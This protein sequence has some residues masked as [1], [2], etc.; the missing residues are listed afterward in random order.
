ML[1]RVCYALSGTETAYGATRSTAMSEVRSESDGRSEVGASYGPTPVLC[2]VRYWHS[3]WV[4][5][6]TPADT[7]VWRLCVSCYACAST[8]SA[9]GA[10]SQAGSTRRRSLVTGKSSPYNPL[11]SGT[12]MTS[13]ARLSTKPLLSYALSGTDVV[14]G[15]TRS[16]GEGTRQQVLAPPF[17]PTTRQYTASYHRA[18]LDSTQARTSRRLLPGVQVR[19]SPLGSVAG[20]RSKGT[21]SVELHAATGTTPR[22]RVRYGPR[23]LLRTPQYHEHLPIPPPVPTH[24]RSKPPFPPLLPMQPARHSATLLD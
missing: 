7:D 1:L 23:P 6:A 3:G 22:T 4:C 8:D 21:P 18:L 14:Y 9:Y 5:S 2:A 19:G 16:V 17:Y 12:N 15:A 24:L 13:G 20:L 11:V 10:T